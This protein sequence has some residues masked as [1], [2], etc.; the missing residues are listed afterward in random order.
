MIKIKN[1]L[2]KNR[3]KIKVNADEICTTLV[4]WA[5]VGMMSGS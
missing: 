3:K 1:E 5:R 4:A 2:N